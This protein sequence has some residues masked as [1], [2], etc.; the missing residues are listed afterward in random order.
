MGRLLERVN[1]VHF[2]F[3]LASTYEDERSQVF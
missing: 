1:Y 3:V 2:Q